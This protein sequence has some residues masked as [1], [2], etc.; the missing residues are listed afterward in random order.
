VRNICDIS[1]NDDFMAFI[2]DEVKIVCPEYRFG[3]SNKNGKYCTVKV[4]NKKFLE[5]LAILNGESFMA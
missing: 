1:T 5:K 2:E 4:I 3:K